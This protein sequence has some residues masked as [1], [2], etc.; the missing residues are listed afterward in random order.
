MTVRIRKS[1]FVGR[2]DKF[3]APGDDIR[4]CMHGIIKGALMAAAGKYPDLMEELCQLGAALGTYSTQTVVAA[5]TVPELMYKFKQELK[6]VSV[7]ARAVCME[8]LAIGVLNYFGAANRETSGHPDMTVPDVA[9][10]TE[11]A[12]WLSSL[13]DVRRKQVQDDMKVYSEYN[14]AL[15]RAKLEG[16]LRPLEKCNKKD[17]GKAAK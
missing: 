7:L 16:E 14:I 17:K 9:H 5:E 8:E 13:P 10:F 2:E 15:D 4:N 11:Q 3:Y 12:S 1:E 6:N